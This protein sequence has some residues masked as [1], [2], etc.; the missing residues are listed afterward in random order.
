MP[1]TAL[2]PASVTFWSQWW[3]RRPVGTP[4]QPPGR[5]TADR[6]LFAAGH[7]PL[8]LF[9]DVTAASLVVS[10]LLYVTLGA[11]VRPMFALMLRGTGQSLLLVGLLHSVFNRT[12]NDNG[13]AATLVPGDA[14]RP[15][16]LVAVVAFIA[17]ATVAVRRMRQRAA[18]V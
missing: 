9:D 6:R 1:S 16:M 4:A 5:L 10:F 17:I 8:A 15:A 11:L 14:R 7:L 12:N 3:A 18:R 13:I 2:A